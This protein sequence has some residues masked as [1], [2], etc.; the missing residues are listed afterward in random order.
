MGT[1]RY[2]TAVQRKLQIP[3]TMSIFLQTEFMALRI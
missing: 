3:G 2:A 1:V